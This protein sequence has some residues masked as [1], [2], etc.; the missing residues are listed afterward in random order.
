VL[1]TR[2]NVENQPEL[3]RQWNIE[4]IPTLLFL[5]GGKELHRIKGIMMRDK[6]R[7]QI[8]GVLLAG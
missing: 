3:T 5:K 4:G 2:V 6:L 8:E 7:R 1:F